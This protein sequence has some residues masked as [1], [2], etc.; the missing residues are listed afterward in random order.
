MSSF[1]SLEDVSLAYGDRTILEEINLHISPGES[2]ALLGKNG[3]GKSSLIK[4][5][6]GRLK[7]MKGRITIEGQD[8]YLY[9][10]AVKNVALVPQSLALFSKLSVK[11]NLLAFGQFASGKFSVTQKLDEVVKLFELQA[12]LGVAA[13]KLSGGWARRVNFAAGLMGGAKIFVLDEPTAGLDLHSI[14][15]FSRWLEPLKK[16][17]VTLI[18][19]SH[20]LAHLGKLVDKVL[21]LHQLRVLEFDA[22]PTLLAKYFPEKK[23]IEFIFSKEVQD[24]T[25]LQ[26]LGLEPFGDEP[27]WRGS[28]LDTQYVLDQVKAH[29][30]QSEVSIESLRIQKPNLTSL[31][32]FLTQV[33]A[34]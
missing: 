31:F 23:E 4:A 9:P 10:D 28:V 24:P 12:Y 11:E 2:I 1:I 6:S 27:C 8:P 7:P 14:E 30:A 5:L 3:A 33:E 16:M 34:R 20:D 21:V 18:L 32:N 22:I 19:I 29:F 17:G 26:E 15:E 25:R 13:G